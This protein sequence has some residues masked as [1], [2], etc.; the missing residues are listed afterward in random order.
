M[1]IRGCL[2]VGVKNA[3][4]NGKLKN[5]LYLYM[6]MKGRF[7]NRIYLLYGLTYDEVSIVVPQT[8]IICE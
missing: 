7:D 4:Y 1:N 5:N 3:K 6:H 8:P 2:L